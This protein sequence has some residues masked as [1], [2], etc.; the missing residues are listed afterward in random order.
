MF[1]A[2]PSLTRTTSVPHATPN[3]PCCC[4]MP[5]SPHLARPHAQRLCTLHGGHL[6]V[7]EDAQDVAD[8]TAL[9]A[10]NLGVASELAGQAVWVGLYMAQDPIFRCA[11]VEGCA[12]R[13]L[14]LGP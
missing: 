2:T 14:L 13:A 6:A 11:H 10:T 1:L 9:L 5:P 12:G 4:F 7:L 8:L 3:P